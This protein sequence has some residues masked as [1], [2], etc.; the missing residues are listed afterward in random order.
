MLA[1]T[2]LH[3]L[4][5][6]TVCIQFLL[7]SEQH[8]IELKKTSVRFVS[9]G[10]SVYDYNKKVNM[11]I[12]FTSVLTY[13]FEYYLDFYIKK[14]IDTI[15]KVPNN[16]SG[17]CKRWRWNWTTGLNEDGQP[18]QSRK[19]RPV[20]PECISGKSQNVKWVSGYELISVV[21]SI[22]FTSVLTYHF[23]YYLDF[24]IK[25]NI[26][27]IHFDNFLYLI[28][29]SFFVNK[30]TSGNTEMP[31]ETNL[32]DVFFNSMKCC[33]EIKRNCMHTV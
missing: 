18:I 15:Q 24:Y 16:T 23:E 3:A 20:K 6:Y 12:V 28:A 26:D 10:I 1:P 7:I 13:H 22:V 32:T 8:F 33:S 29:A 17:T 14:N 5:Y 4:L 27:T 2:V 9:I 31:M 25:K 19:T 11:S 21:L 30:I